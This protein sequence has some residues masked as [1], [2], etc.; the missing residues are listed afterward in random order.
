MCHSRANRPR[1]DG[2]RRYDWWHVVA[3]I[4]HLCRRQ[5]YTFGYRPTGVKRRDSYTGYDGLTPSLV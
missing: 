2:L 4:R 3:R 5:M 1:H